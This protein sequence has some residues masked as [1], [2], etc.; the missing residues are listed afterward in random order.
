M[1]DIPQ[2]K[3]ELFRVLKYED[4]HEYLKNAVVHRALESYRLIEGKDPPD[5]LHECYYIL[6]N[7]CKEILR[8]H[9]EHKEN[10]TNH[11]IRIAGGCCDRCT[12]PQRLFIRH[13]MTSFR[14]VAEMR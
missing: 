11:Q 13:L 6:Y 7:K 14:Q 3:E 8:T 9:Y 10:K 1:Y 12:C 4:A 5:L 2:A